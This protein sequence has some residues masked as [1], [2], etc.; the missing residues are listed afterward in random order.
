MIRVPIGPRLRLTPQREPVGSARF[1]LDGRMS[2]AAMRRSS[3]AP[4]SAASPTSFDI[5]VPGGGPW[6]ISFDNEADAAGFSRDLAVR[7]R[8]V[9]VSLKTSRGWRTIDELQDELYEMRRR[10]LFATMRR[11]IYQA[12]LLIGISLFIY[13]CALYC[14]DPEKPP[15]EVV[16]TALGDAGAAASAA[17]AWAADL[18][19]AVC[20]VVVRAVP[21]VDVQRCVALAEA[22]EVRSC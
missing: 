10:G 16:V 3:A 2:L 7:Q 19:M 9:Q 8:L 5:E 4:M 15:T 6:G 21:A 11:L 14:A 22:T 1:S 12:S 17:G 20:G 18:G 13:A